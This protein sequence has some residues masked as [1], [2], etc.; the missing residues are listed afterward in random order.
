MY[1]FM[2]S[3]LEIQPSRE[4]V[5][6]M[7]WISGGVFNEIFHFISF[8]QVSKYFSCRALVLMMHI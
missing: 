3:F 1:D 6:N 7:V 4:K 5:L 2:C 8:T